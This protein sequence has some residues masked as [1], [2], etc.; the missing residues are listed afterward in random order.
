MYVLLTCRSSLFFIKIE[1]P[2]FRAARGKCLGATLKGGGS[3]HTWG[4]KTFCY[5]A[6]KRGVLLYMGSESF[7]KC[8]KGPQGVLLLNQGSKYKSERYCCLNYLFFVVR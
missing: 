6:D 4:Q 7:R 3:Y 2:K 8:N 5:L 1:F